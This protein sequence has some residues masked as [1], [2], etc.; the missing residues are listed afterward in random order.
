MLSFTVGCCIIKSPKADVILSAPKR[1]GGAAFLWR[2]TSVDVL[3]GLKID[4]L[5]S[6][7]GVDE[8]EDG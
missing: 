1:W 8:A 3:L 6:E 2:M 7:N 5:R 4:D